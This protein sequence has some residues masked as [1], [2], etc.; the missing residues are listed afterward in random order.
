M[1][2][3][4]YDLKCNNG[5]NVRFGATRINHHAI[6]FLKKKKKKKKTECNRFEE[7]FGSSPWQKPRWSNPSFP[8]VVKCMY[9]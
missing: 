9:L 1:H 6:L 8:G 3:F 4:K 5:K 7:R 2:E